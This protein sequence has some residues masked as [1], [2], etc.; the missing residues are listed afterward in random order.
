MLCGNGSKLALLCNLS[1]VGGTLAIADGGQ[2]A[3]GGL[4]TIYSKLQGNGSFTGDIQNYGT[5]APGNSA[6]RLTINGNYTPGASAFGTIQIELGGTVPGTTYDQ[7]VVTGDATL[8]GTLQV[9]L[10]NSF[11]PVPGNSFDILD[12]GSLDSTFDVVSLP[13]LSSDM[14]WVTSQLYTSGVISV[15]AVPK[16]AAASLL[17]AGGLILACAAGRG[18]FGPHG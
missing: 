14:R 3:V 17:L 13:K 6:G 9:L 15:A 5:V 12:W 1:I 7:L 18:R 10:T 4:T 11:T 8:G 2:V 16:P